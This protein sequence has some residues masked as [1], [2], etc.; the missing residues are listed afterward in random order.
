MMLEVILYFAIILGVGFASNSIF[1]LKEENPFAYLALGIMVT[2]FYVLAMGFVG[3]LGVGSLVPLGA[4]ALYGWLFRLPAMKFGKEFLY[5][6]LAFVFLLTIFLIGSSMLWLED[7]DPVEHSS[8]LVYIGEFHSILQPIPTYVRYLAPYPAVYDAFMALP[9]ELTGD[10]P[11]TLKVVNAILCALAIPFAFLWFKERYGNYAIYMMI[12]LAILPSFMS[13]FIWSQTLA[14]LMMFPALY[15]FE[16]A[17]LPMNVNIISFNPEADFNY[18]LVF[19]LTTALVFI[20]QPSVAFIFGCIM[21]LYIIVERRFSDITLLVLAGILAFAIYWVPVLALYGIDNTMNL[22]HVSIITG[23]DDSSGGI[24]YGLSDFMSAPTST[25]IDQPEG[26]GIGIFMLVVFGA[27]FAINQKYY[28]ELALLVFCLLGVE[29]N[30]LPFKLFPHRFWVF[31]AVPVAIVAAM[32][33]K[34]T[35]DIFYRDTPWHWLVLL[36][37][38][39]VLYETSLEPK[40]E[41]QMM[42]WPPGMFVTEQQFAGYLNLQSKL[43][44]NTLVYDYCSKE[45][46]MD[47][48]GL[49][50]LVWDAEVWN[51]K[52]VAH[53]A[54]EDR[55]F[56]Q[57]KG[58]EYAV[59]DDSC[60][61]ETNLMQVQDKLRWLDETYELRDDLSS[62][63]FFVFEVE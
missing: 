6:T 43:P 44:K 53:S 12:I 41:V 19:I 31:L 1:K 24:I 26:W 11:N 46:M 58:Y 9:Y 39:V 29:G 30:A 4:V 5:N 50:G 33:V 48:I 17:K 34:K 8:G 54:V 62:D 15:F 51:Q 61:N 18:G 28:F 47:G 37:V 23:N 38:V 16:K 52:G 21:L 49:R 60:L 25:K 13:H 45:T 57:E 35:V 2:C 20:T 56:L 36:L 63:R 3:L 27:L 55:L 10:A 59:L 22:I 40:M 42:K 32:A 14:V 7:N